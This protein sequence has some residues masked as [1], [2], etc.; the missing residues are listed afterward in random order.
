MNFK[1]KSWKII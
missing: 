1:F